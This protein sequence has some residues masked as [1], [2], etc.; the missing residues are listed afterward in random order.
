MLIMRPL[1]VFMVAAAASVAQETPTFRSGTALVRVDVQVVEKGRPVT[2]LTSGDFVL[3]DE[4]AVR[5]I[6][7]FGQESE[8][9]QLVLL[10]DVSGSMGRVLREMA[11]VGRKALSTLKGDDQV[12]VGVFARRSKILVELTEEKDL[13]VRALQEAPLERDMGA[14]TSINDAL[15]SVAEYL[16]RQS[17][18]AGRRALVLLTDN[19]GM[20]YQTPDE[21]VLEALAGVDAVVNAI[22]PAGVKPLPEQPASPERNPDFTPANVFRL[23][24]E[25][26]GEVLRTDKAGVRFGELVERVRLRYTLGL[27]AAAAPAGT[28]RRLDVQLSAEAL[29]RYPKAVV[30][31]RAGYFTTRQ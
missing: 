6:E 30:R 31:A 22:V 11:A 2:G 13:A 25:T 14:G 7:Y 18:W 3:R 1:L 17:G 27:R 16:R 9:V 23:A 24:E 5:P 20:H 4:G 28:F 12:A 15:L 29:R 19:G 8:P 21:K 26:G 10:L